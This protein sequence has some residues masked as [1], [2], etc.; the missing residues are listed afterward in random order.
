MHLFYD[1][2]WAIKQDTSR[3]PSIP[4]IKKLYRYA[5]KVDSLPQYQDG[6]PVVIKDEEYWH[7]IRTSWA[8]LDYQWDPKSQWHSLYSSYVYCGKSD[9]IEAWEVESVEISGEE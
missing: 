4:A 8:E 9:M 3:F 2:D 5:F 7:G 1:Y 6:G